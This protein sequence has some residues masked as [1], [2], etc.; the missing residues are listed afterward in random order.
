MFYGGKFTLPV[1]V[2]V[3]LI[4]IIMGLCYL[5]IYIRYK[6]PITEYFAIK[7]TFGDFYA[8]ILVYV[9]YLFTNFS[10]I[11]ILISLSKYIGTLSYFS[12]LNNYFC[13]VGLSISVILLMSYINYC[14]IEASK[15]VGNTISI[16]LLI[17][18]LGIILSSLR[19]FDLKKITAGTNVKWDSIVLS[20]IIAFFL[21]NGYDSIVKVSGEVIDESNT[22]TGL[23]ATL[24]LTSILYISIIIS[25]LCVLGFNTS[26]TSFSPLIKIYEVLYGPTFGFMA[27]IFGFINMFNTGFLSSLTATRFIYGC[28]KEKT[29]AFPDFWS[30]L[31]E[32]KAPINAIIVSLIIC[33]IFA[34]FNNEVVLSVFANF[35]L[36]II[37]ISICLCVIYIRWKERNDIEKQKSNN[38]IMGNIN[39][40]P[41]IIIIEVIVLIYLFYNVLKNRFYLDK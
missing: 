10:C 12:F 11:T 25:S 20:T 27:F 5:E 3:T 14:G 4:S 41:I 30:K 38:Y 33:V 22:S 15:I 31:N 8:Q 24:G 40:I 21:F 18:L 39:N 28:G 2:V 16:A 26:V 23:Y 32:N 9:I 34:L 37:L 17:F 6:S 29:I 36:F 19:F 13:Q 7:D 35:S 1:F